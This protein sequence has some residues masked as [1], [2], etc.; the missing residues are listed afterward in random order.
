[1]AKPSL[2]EI[3]HLLADAVIVRNVCDLDLLIFL[4]RHPR[5][6]LTS[7]QVAALVGYPMKQIA[8]SLDLFIDSGLLERTQNALHAARMYLLNLDGPHGNPLKPLLDLGS[9]REGRR[10]IIEALRSEASPNQS[11]GPQ[12]KVRIMRVA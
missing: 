10:R 8:E 5:T 2:R 3:E 7:E 4:W 6:L 11:A 9:T 12:D 1:M